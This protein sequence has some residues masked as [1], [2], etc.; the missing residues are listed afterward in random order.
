MASCRTCGLPLGPMPSD[1]AD[2][3]AEAV[4]WGPGAAVCELHKLAQRRSWRLALDDGQ[5]EG[6]HGPWIAKYSLAGEGAPN[7]SAE[8]AIARGGRL[9]LTPTGGLLAA[10]DGR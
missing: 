10:A 3:S 4:A 2:A 5:P 6:G 1:P 9:A 7:G 8:V